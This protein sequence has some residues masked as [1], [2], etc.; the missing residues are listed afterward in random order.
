MRRSA[1]ARQRDERG[2]TLIELMVVVM[3]IGVLLAI[4]IPTFLSARNRSSDRL[5]QTSLRVALTNARALY[6]DG[7]SFLPADP[8]G[9]SA[10]E[11]SIVFLDATSASDDGKAVSVVSTSAASWVAAAWS[12]SG[13]CFFLSDTGGTEPT[14]YL[15]A[16]DVACTAADGAANVDRFT[17]GGWS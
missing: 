2:F 3:M 12:A 8:A 1:T 14:A 16:S 10:I 4:A 17:T 7:S 15:A 6:S 9:L 13:T 11:G 5:A